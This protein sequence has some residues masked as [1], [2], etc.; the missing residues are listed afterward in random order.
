M[1]QN[2]GEAIV[3]LREKRGITRYRLAKKST[4]SYSYL[5]ALEESKHNPSIEVLEKLACGL[6]IP[7]TELI[8]TC[9]SS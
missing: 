2:V 1:N 3:R 4:L 9:K 5:A 6:E 7:L 8:E